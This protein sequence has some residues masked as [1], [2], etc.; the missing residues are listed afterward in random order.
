MYHKNI[1]INIQTFKQY[2]RHEFY[3]HS[4]TSFLLHMESEK[5]LVSGWGEGIGYKYLCGG[6][7][8]FLN[9]ILLTWK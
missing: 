9:I 1:E 2:I 4:D 6:V 7:H 3:D 8:I 5:Y